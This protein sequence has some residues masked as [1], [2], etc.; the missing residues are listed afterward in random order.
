MDILAVLIN[1][2]MIITMAVIAYVQLAPKLI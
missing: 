2:A 1:L